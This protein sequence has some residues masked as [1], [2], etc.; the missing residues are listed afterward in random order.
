MNT[1]R[2]Y[3]TANA[4]SMVT[5]IAS[6]ASTMATNIVNNVRTNV[7]NIASG[8]SNSASNGMFGTVVFYGFIIGILALIV[9]YFQTI[10]YYGSE[11][12]DNVKMQWQRVFGEKEENIPEE[13]KKMM[14][15]SERP[16]GIPGASDPSLLEKI[17]EKLPQRA[18]VFNVSRNIYT[19]NDA[20]AVCRALGADLATYDQVKEAYEHGADWCNY[21]WVKG[22][23]AVYPT[24]K[25]TFEKL[26][27]GPES[28][29]KACGN[30]GING[31][32]F[33]NP[34][35]RFGVNCYGMRPSKRATDAISNEIQL[36][37]SADEVEFDKKVQRYRDQLD[38]M[39]VLP[40]SR[41]FRDGSWGSN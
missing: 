23:M 2:N 13:A 16:G 9:Y 8:T 37:K 4:T 31:G 40:F 30:V 35:L 39:Q 25:E 18:E 20:S 3:A 6:N 34:E 28:S 27:K 29:R 19:F 5:N 26:Q 12:M 10:K 21:G 24:Q 22:Q 38:Q 7:S 11:F 36:P 17:G 14:K 32:Y 15:P 33:D 1:S 41:G